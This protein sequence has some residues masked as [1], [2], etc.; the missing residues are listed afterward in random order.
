MDRYQNELSQAAQR[1]AEIIKARQPQEGMPLKVISGEVKSVTSDNSKA[2]VVV[3][4]QELSVFNKSKD[5]LTAGESVWLGYFKTLADAVILFRNG[6]STPSSGGGVGEDLGNGNERFNDYVNNTCAEDEGCK[7]NTLKGS[8]NKVLGGQANLLYGFNNTANNTTTG[9]LIG[10][11]SNSAA[12]GTYASSITG[13]SNTLLSGSSGTGANTVSGENNTVSGRDN[14]VSGNQ[15]GVSASRCMAVGYKNS[16]SGTDQMAAGREN[17]IEGSNNFVIGKLNHLINNDNNENNICGGEQ[18]YVYS[19]NNM[20]SGRYN[21][22]SGTGI[23]NVIGGQSNQANYYGY[24]AVF[25]RQNQAWG[26]SIV[27][28]N[29]CQAD[30]F[31]Q[32]GGQYCFAGEQSAAFGY[33]AYAGVDQ[34]ALDRG[35]SVNYA[36]Q[37][38]LGHRCFSFGY[39]LHNQSDNAFVCGRY[40]EEGKNH[41]AFIVGSGHQARP[42]EGETEDVRANVFDIAWSGDTSTQGSYNTLGADYSEHEEWADGNPDNEDRAGHFVTY[43][44]NKIRYANSDDDYILG[45]VSATPAVVGDGDIGYWRGRF[46][47]DVFGRVIYEKAEVVRH[48]V[49]DEGEDEEYTV[50]QDVPKTAS[51]Y[52]P[53]REYI[54]RSE[55]PEWSPVGT[56]GKLIVVDDG[57]CEVDGYCTAADGGIATKAD[58]GYRV[59]E[60]L[61]DT[62]IRIRL[63]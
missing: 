37:S 38:A 4:E 20:V 55:R 36:S 51:D 30:T 6:P 10:G 27:S 58:K 41:Y 31:A 52:D 59:I 63:R 28:G 45:V 47:T 11:M 15:N 34:D 62:H 35:A 33:R 39:F 54:P 42:E 2:I 22:V 12:V 29:L 53:T 14:I 32:A 7:F 21:S 24:N 5:K 60:R 8:S 25:G 57:T 18:N 56:H 40:N 61:D 43:V 9:N 26:Y 13:V 3:N 50:I 44:G 48:R 1:L 49:N 46:E 17:V 19:A 23:C 16:V